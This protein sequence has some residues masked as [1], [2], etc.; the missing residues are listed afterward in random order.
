MRNFIRCLLRWFDQA[1][2][3]SI[4]IPTNAAPRVEFGAEKL[5]RRSNQSAWIRPSPT[6]KYFRAQHS[7]EPA[8]RFG[9]SPP[10][11][12]AWLARM[13]TMI[14]GP[15]R[16]T[17]R[18]RFTVAWN[19]QSGSARSENLPD[20]RKFSGRARDDNCAAR[21][22]ACKKLTSCPAATFTNIPSRRNCSRGFTTK[23]CGRSIWIFSS[24]I[25]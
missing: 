19:W 17:I 13:I 1:E 5:R 20:D 10:K 24:R 18:A 14:D 16:R 4:V 23:K 7:S 9:K 3:I 11:D 22:S 25:A 2:T 12:F 15:V 8:A 6:R 21:A